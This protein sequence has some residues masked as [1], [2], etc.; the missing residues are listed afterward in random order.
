MKVLGLI[1]LLKTLPPNLEVVISN[2]EMGEF[3]DIDSA[4]QSTLVTYRLGL[5]NTDE[6][7]EH[8]VKVTYPHATI[9]SSRQV[10]LLNRDTSLDDL[11]ESIDS[12][13]EV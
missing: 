2:N 1:S 7:V 3:T 12:I 13:E 10:V 8:S 5:F 6:E 9:L 4:E 11:P